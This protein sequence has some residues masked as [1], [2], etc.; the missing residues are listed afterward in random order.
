MHFGVLLWCD[1]TGATG[2]VPCMPGTLH[3]SEGAARG[4]APAPV[5]VP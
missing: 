5:T 4:P 3:A 1:R 2:P